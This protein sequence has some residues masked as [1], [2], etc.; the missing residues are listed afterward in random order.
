MSSI[1]KLNKNVEIICRDPSGPKDT[2][3]QLIPKA[4][5]FCLV[6]REM[7]KEFVI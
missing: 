2:L 3:P 5:A 7:L 6:S 4:F 1:Y